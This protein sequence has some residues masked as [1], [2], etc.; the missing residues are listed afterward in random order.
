MAY[1]RTRGDQLAIVHGQRDPDS[2]KVVQRIL[3]TIYSKA[4]A[5]EVLGRASRGVSRQFSAGL[6]DQYPSIRFEWKKIRKSIEENIDALPD[7]YAYREERLLGRFREDLTA[8]AR[9]LYLADPQALGSAAEMFASHRH[10]LEII[11][12]LIRWRLQTCDAEQNEF[13][14][15][16]QYY[17]R[18]VLTRDGPPSD[19]EEMAEESYLKGDLDR[20]EASFS[21]LLD[22]FQNYPDGHNYLGQIALDRGNVEEA[23]EHFT[24]AANIGRRQFPKRIAKDQYWTDLDTRPYVRA[25]RNLALAQCRA[26]RWEVAL[27]ACDRLEEECGD[28]LVARSR[29]ATIFLNTGRWAEAVDSARSISAIWASECFVVAFAHFERGERNEALKYFLHASLNHPLAARVLIGTRRRKASDYQGQEDHGIGV[30]LAGSLEQYLKQHGKRSRRF[31]S[32]I[33]RLPQVDAMLG[34]VEQTRRRWDHQHSRGVREA[35]DRLHEMQ[36]LEYAEER[37]RELSELVLRS[38]R[39]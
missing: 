18:T 12:D 31:F 8:F 24:T 6:E 13:T 38:R 32:R 3:F 9:Q 20:A 36:S 5:R 10:E 4:E 22:C 26:S 19:V 25:L 30:A 35:L 27:E 37:A 7:E 29:R 21:L 28:T 15:D 2:G 1:V 16:N 14:R 34:E 39:L 33:L 23:I 11:V 17:W